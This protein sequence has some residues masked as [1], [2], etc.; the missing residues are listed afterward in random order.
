MSRPAFTVASAVL[1]SL[2]GPLGAAEVKEL[3]VQKVGNATLFAVTLEA[4]RAVYWP[5]VPG[6]SHPTWDGRRLRDVDADAA[7]PG[8]GDPAPAA[9]AA[10][11]GARRGRHHRRP[12]PRALVGGGPA[13]APDA[14]RGQ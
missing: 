10:A 2:A 9:A 11:P 7:R 1:L 5:R 4:P 3:Q 6:L 14:V 8:R 12:L 13:G